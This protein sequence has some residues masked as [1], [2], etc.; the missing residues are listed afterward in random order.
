MRQGRENNQGLPCNVCDC[1][2]EQNLS[3]KKQ[4]L[5]ETV[6]A[7][8]STLQSF[9]VSISFPSCFVY[10]VRRRV[11][12]FRK[13]SL[14]WRKL[15]FNCPIH[16]MEKKES[17]C[18]SLQS[19]SFEGQLLSR[20]RWWMKA[21]TGLT[22]WCVAY[23]KKEHRS[24]RSRGRLVVRTS[25]CGRDNRCS[26]HRLDKVYFLPLVS[27]HRLLLQRS[28]LLRQRRSVVIFVN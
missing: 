19:Y 17:S 21:K 14:L 13:H 24:R 25:R 1:A 18:D 5:E 28:L 26:T 16:C 12:I 9:S 23:R 10:Y 22:T 6:A 11:R 4:I 2:R 7:T 8:Q 27:L 3:L 20:R 15:L